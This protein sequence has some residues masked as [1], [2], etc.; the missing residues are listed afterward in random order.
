M[1]VFLFYPLVWSYLYTVVED[2]HLESLRF[3]RLHHFLLHE[4]GVEVCFISKVVGAKEPPY[5]AHFRDL[6]WGY[7]EAKVFCL[8]GRG[9][10]VFTSGIVESIFQVGCFP[11][12]SQ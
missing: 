3:E 11:T 10:V 6:Q 7:G 12:K 4:R 2:F 5:R 9:W 1:S 8:W